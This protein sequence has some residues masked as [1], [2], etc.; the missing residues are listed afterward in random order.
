M[1]GGHQYLERAGLIH[2][3]PNDRFDFL[4]HPQPQRQ[5]TVDAPRQLAYQASA[6]H[7]LMA[8]YFGF[9]R[10]F[11]QGRYECL[12]PTHKAAMV[13]TLRCFVEARSF[14]NR[15]VGDTHAKILASSAATFYL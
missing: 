9:L 4:Q 11:F 5:E 12:A 7:Q 1:K 3:L 10:I 15:I 2:F 6:N 13:R 14:S 8:R